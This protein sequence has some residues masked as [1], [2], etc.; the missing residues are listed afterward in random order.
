MAAARLDVEAALRHLRS[1][2]PRL[3]TLIERHGPPRLQRTRNSFQSLARSI[4]YQQLSG[5]AAATICR[6][7]LQLFP[8]HRFPTPAA[9]RSMPVARLRS[10][11]LSRQKATCLHALAR[12]YLQGDIRPRRFNQM[13]AAEITVTLTRVKGIGPWTA[14]M[15]MIF[16]LNRPDVLPVGD[17][18]VR[19]GMQRL[20][21]LATLP[22]AETM[23]RVASP[24]RP[25]R[26][27]AS[28]YLWRMLDEQPVP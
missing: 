8:T 13:S 18:G 14:D 5:K 6:R 20:C 1:A 11:G 7:F 28:W 23:R 17:L 15:F 12:N 21:T 24:W 26:S 16:A 25:F 19:K 2:E 3:R 4:I 22:D 10:A 9:V 27:A